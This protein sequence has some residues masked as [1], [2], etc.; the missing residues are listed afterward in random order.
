MEDKIKTI[1]EKCIEA[2]CTV[3]GICSSHDYSH[4]DCFACQMSNRTVR[5]ADVLLA[6]QGVGKNMRFNLTNGGHRDNLWIRCDNIFGGEEDSECPMWNLLKDDLTQQ[7][8]ETI[9]FLH[10]LITSEGES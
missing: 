1:R 6:I 7:S 9:D 5:L 8:P 4:S 3:G 2:G 10:N